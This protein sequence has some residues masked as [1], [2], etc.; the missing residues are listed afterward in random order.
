MQTQ[1]Y[2]HFPAVG[3]N[4]GNTT[5]SYL[6]FENFERV[7]N[8]VVRL[9]EQI[10]ERVHDELDRVGRGPAVA[11]VE[12]VSPRATHTAVVAAIAALSHFVA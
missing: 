12:E 7:S 5:V 11:A 1:K 9:A 2:P 3:I 4:Q 10:R 6:G 8:L